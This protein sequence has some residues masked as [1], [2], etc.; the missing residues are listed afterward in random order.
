MSNTEYRVYHD[1]NGHVKYYMLHTGDSTAES[2]SNFIRITQEQYSAS[3]TD[4]RVINGE[5]Q[6]LS[7]ES[8]IDFLPKASR[9]IP[10][11]K[12]V[13][14]DNHKIVE[15]K[16]INKK[17]MLTWIVNNIC[18]NHCMYCPAI[19]HSGS[20]HHYEWSHAEKFINDFFDRYSNVTCSLSGGEPTVSPFFKPLINL[21]HSRGGEIVLTTNLVRSAEWWED[22]K[23]KFTSISVS[24]HPEFTD[25]QKEDE[26][27]QK[28]LSLDLYTL[29]HI[30]VM[31]LPS[32]WEQCYN[33]YKKIRHMIESDELAAS[34]EMVRVLPDYGRG[35]KFCEIIY[36]AEQNNILQ[37]KHY[38]NSM[39]KRPYRSTVLRRKSQRSDYMTADNDLYEFTSAM[40]NNLINNYKT[41]FRGWECD[42]G[43]ESLF[44]NWNGLVKRGN[45]PE[46]GII[47]SIVDGIN[48]PV[49]S[50]ICNTAHCHCPP[51]VR[52]SKRIL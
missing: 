30:R 45:C 42:I 12:P 2:A 1:S 38:V 46:G 33:F 13:S 36:T 4:V 35:E 3:R 29:L 11:P 25:Q 23:D 22:I 51:D 9:D 44:V 50:V 14:W 27:I 21:I 41:D 20:N 18:T 6:N 15:I 24:Y 34:L 32:H 5:L 47:G 40:T 43:I 8:K 28:F 7:N 10:A 48:W 49:G 17:V 52:V 37:D 19:L 26:L 16:N 39:K 31:M